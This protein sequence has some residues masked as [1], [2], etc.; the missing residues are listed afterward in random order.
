MVFTV[1]LNLVP[2]LLLLVAGEVAVRDSGTPDRSRA[3]VHGHESLALEVVRRRRAQRGDPAS[4]SRSTGPFW[5]R[6]NGSAGPSTPAAGRPTACTSAAS[7]D[8]AVPS[9]VCPFGIVRARHRVALVGDSFTFG[10]E[11]SYEQTWGLPARAGPGRRRAGAQLRRGRLRCR[12]GVSP[13]RSRCPPVAAR[14]GHLRTHHPRSVSIHGRLQLRQLPGLALPL[15]QAALRGGRRPARAA[16]RAASFAA[17]DPGSRAL[18]TTSPSSSTTGATGQMTGRGTRSIGPISTAFSRPSIAGGPGPMREA[19]M[20]AWWPSTARSP[21]VHPRGAR[22]RLE[23]DRRVLPV[24]SRLPHSGP[25]A[26]LAEPRPDDVAR[27]AHPPHRLDG[28][29]GQVSTRPIGS[30]PVTTPR[31]A[32]PPWPTCLRDD[33]RGLLKTEAPTGPRAARRS[34]TRRNRGAP[35]LSVSRPGGGACIKDSER[36]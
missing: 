20:S 22:R 26:R 32:M 13:L 15:R 10:L 28:M 33:I 24:P 3:G 4:R 31:A 25:E 1:A 21:R 34:G 2:V 7:R 16:E 18:S 23:P 14:R 6:T 36:Q 12:P 17:G 29:P 11:V 19:P 30:V 8:C 5:C 35:R 9:R 27:G